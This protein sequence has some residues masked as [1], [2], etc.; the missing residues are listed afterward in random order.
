MLMLNICREDKKELLD[1]KEKR[2][3]L[4]KIFVFPFP[5]PSTIPASDRN[6]RYM[7]SDPIRS[8]TPHPN[9][10]NLIKNMLMSMPIY[11]H[12]SPPYFFNARK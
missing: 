2:P 4:Q 7:V 10:R 12:S 11:I 6:L 3:K 5:T 8:R 1:R 9:D